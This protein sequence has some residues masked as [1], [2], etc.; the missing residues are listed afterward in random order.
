MQIK[1]KK[2]FKIMFSD[3][4]L[5]YTNV[6]LSLLTAS[7]GDIL[8]QGLEVVQ[9]KKVSIDIKRNFN[10][11]MTGLGSGI[12]RHIWYKQLDRRLRG[13]GLLVAVKKVILDQLICSP[14]C[15][16]NLFVTLAILEKPVFNDAVEEFTEKSGE[17]YLTEWMMSPPTQ[18]INF[19]LV[20]LRFRL[21]FDNSMTI[22]F[23]TYYSYIRYKPRWDFEKCDSD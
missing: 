13:E 19:Y 18:L 22:V 1:L 15:I 10:M 6:V 16:L 12:F 17:I 3:T 5:V 8:E 2:L 21:L 14:I 23:D 11:T 7:I 9:K 20:P 4:Y